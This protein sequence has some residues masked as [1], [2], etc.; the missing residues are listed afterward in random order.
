MR[1]LSHSF[2]PLAGHEPKILILGS[3]P[4]R[5]SLRHNQY[6]AN[7]RNRFWRVISNVFKVQEPL[8]YE[9]KVKMLDDNGIALWDVLAYAEREGSLD[10]NIKN[11][12]PND[13]IGFLKTY[14]SIKIIGFNGQKA[15]SKFCEYFDCNNLKVR[16]LPLRS[17]SPANCRFSDE[18]IIEDW[19]RLI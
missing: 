5:E 1:N 12:T 4:G 14:P 11:D 6:Y 16:L 13:I 15:Y 3:M 17:T 8:S 19:S 7:A 2:L 18:Q 9:D 10:Y